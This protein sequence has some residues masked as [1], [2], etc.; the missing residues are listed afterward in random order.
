MHTRSHLGITTSL[1]VTGFSGKLYVQFFGHCVAQHTTTLGFSGASGL[2][3]T[4]C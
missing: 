4:K 2:N 1:L 3:V